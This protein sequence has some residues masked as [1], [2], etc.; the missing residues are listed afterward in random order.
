MGVEDEVERREGRGM[1]AVG[2]VDGEE[3]WREGREGRVVF[4]LHISA[5]IVRQELDMFR[6]Y[7]SKTHQ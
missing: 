5:L 3:V 7:Y 4:D 6:L 1:G 2:R